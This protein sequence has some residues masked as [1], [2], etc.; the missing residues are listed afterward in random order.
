MAEFLIHS[1]LTAHAKAMPQHPALSCN[2]E[3]LSYRELDERSNQLAHALLA[4]G[5][6]LEDRIGLFLHKGL[7]L[8]VAIYGIL[9]AG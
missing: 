8:G 9:K 5:V 2:G 1:P 4:S 6:E 7:D 3:T